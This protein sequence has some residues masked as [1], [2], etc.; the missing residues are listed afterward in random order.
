MFENNYTLNKEQ[1]IEMCDLNVLQSISN[2]FWVMLVQWQRIS[3]KQS[4]RWKHLSQLKASAFF[5][6]QKNSYLYEMQQL[7]LRISYT[8]KWMMVPYSS[9]NIRLN[10]CRKKF[11][12]TSLK[13]LLKAYMS[14]CSLRICKDLSNSSFWLKLPEAS[15]HSRCNK[16]FSLVMRVRQNNL[17]CLYQKGFKI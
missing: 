4:A 2:L 14:L 15:P 11:Y 1:R 12:R 6:L 7:I 8:I 5:S 9:C 3:H 13:C 17:E 10:F 16:Y